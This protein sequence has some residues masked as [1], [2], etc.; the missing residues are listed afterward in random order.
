M[1]C[2]DQKMEESGRERKRR[3]IKEGKKKVLE[4]INGKCR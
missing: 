3:K 4:G 1:V 2:V